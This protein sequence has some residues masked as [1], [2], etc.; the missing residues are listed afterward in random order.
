[1]NIDPWSVF[2]ANF[3]MMPKP[4]T[5]FLTLLDMGLYFLTMWNVAVARA[6]YKVE[7]PSVEGPIEFRRIFRVQ[8]NTLE[9]LA[10]HLPLLWL[11]AFAMDDV[12]ATAVGVIWTFGRV[13]Y[14]IRYYQ[15]PNRRHKG[16]V[17]SM[18]ANALLFLG[19]VAGTIASF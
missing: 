15:K 1:M 11:A 14:A 3:G 6:K 18:V 9:Q 12:F 7:P 19:A 13:L 2:T 5:A 8:M 17:V 10:L 16:F 4:C